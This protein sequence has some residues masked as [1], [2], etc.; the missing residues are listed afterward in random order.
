[1]PADTWIQ[2]IDGPKQ[3]KDLINK[4][5]S[6]L[7]DGKSYSETGKGFFK[8]GIKQTYNINLWGGYSFKATDNHKVK[9]IKRIASPKKKER[10]DFD[11]KTV[12][13]LEPGDLVVLNN[14]RSTSWSGNGTEPE[15]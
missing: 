7:V 1:M 10:Y 14:N 6:V 3:V 5:F 11:W 12:A 15:G 8:T 2:T 13:E 4:P 9:I